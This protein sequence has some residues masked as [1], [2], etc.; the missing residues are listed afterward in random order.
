[1]RFEAK[2]ATRHRVALGATLATALVLALVLAAC[3]A[4]DLLPFVEPDLC[5]AEL[6]V[7]P[8]ITTGPPKKPS[9]SRSIPPAT[10]AELPL[11]VLLTI[12]TGARPASRPSPPPNPSHPGSPVTTLV[13]TVERSIEI[14]PKLRAKMP[15]PVVMGPTSQGSSSSTRLFVTRVSSRMSPAKATIPPPPASGARATLS[16]TTTRSRSRLVAGMKL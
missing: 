10:V 2:A 5:V 12:R 7:T 6:E 9:L 15:P 13:E 14:G 16:R 4:T 1:M 3:A 11:T 8:Q